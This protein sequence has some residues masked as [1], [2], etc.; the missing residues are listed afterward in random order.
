MREFRDFLN[1][2]GLHR[3]ILWVFEEDVYCRKSDE[4]RK[5]F[6]LK[7][8]LPSENEQLARLHFELGKAKG[9]GLGLAAFASCDEG[10]CCSFLVPADELDAQYMLTGAQHLKYSFVVERMPVTTVVVRSGVVWKL[11]GMLNFLFRHGNHFVY[12]E[13]K[14]NLSNNRL[15]E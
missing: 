11:I 10:L 12:L 3:P 9:F 15:R 5:D 4:Y 14:S 1:A 7:L 2:N 6:L 8:P 13:S